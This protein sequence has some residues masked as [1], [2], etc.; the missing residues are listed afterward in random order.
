MVVLPLAGKLVLTTGRISA[1][2]TTTRN[3]LGRDCGYSVGLGG[4]QTLWLFCDTGILDP[5]RQLIGFIGGTPVAVGPYT[6]G[7]A[8]GSLSEL[9]TPPAAPT[10][11]NGHGPNGFC[12][13]GPGWCLDGSLCGSDGASYAASWLSSAT[14]GPA[15]YIGAY[16]SQDLVAMTYV[17]RRSRP[18]RRRDLPDAAQTL[19]LSP[20]HGYAAHSVRTLVRHASPSSARRRQNPPR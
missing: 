3:K 1:R 7:Q 8:P 15:R 13:S 5:A 12:P 19:E 10:L 14:P 20:V 9:P 17:E 2:E 16:W 4:R 11:P 6:V 18:R